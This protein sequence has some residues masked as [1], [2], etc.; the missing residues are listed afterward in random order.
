MPSNPKKLQDCVIKEE[1]KRVT[2]EIIVEAD[3]PESLRELLLDIEKMCED[4]E[5]KYSENTVGLD[6]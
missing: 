2:K 4:H 3:T 1:P 6:Y 5:A